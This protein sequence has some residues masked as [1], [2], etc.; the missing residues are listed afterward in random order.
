MVETTNLF[1]RY[2][3]YN[4][5]KTIEKLAGVANLEKSFVKT[6]SLYVNKDINW[7]NSVQS[8]SL[9]LVLDWV[10]VTC[11]VKFQKDEKIRI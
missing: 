10:N 3:S 8:K 9:G 6:T 11:L 2:Q 1:Q 7:S 4:G 5:F